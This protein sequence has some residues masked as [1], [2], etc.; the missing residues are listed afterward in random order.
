LKQ[1]NL[2]R[3][4]NGVI[5]IRDRFQ[6]KN[7]LSLW[8]AAVQGKHDM[9]RF[10]S[11]PFWCVPLNDAFQSGG[12]L[13]VYR[14]E[15][16]GL[17]MFTEKRVRG[18]VL[19]MPVDGMW[20]LGTPLL[21]SHPQ[22]LLQS[23][24]KYWVAHRLSEGVR[25]VMISGL[26]PENPLCGSRFWSRVKAWETGASGRM[27]ASLE[28]G[29]DGFMSRRSKNFRS[30][31][32][33]TVKAAEE[34]GIRVEAMPNGPEPEL[35]RQIL[36]R[37]FSL[38]EGSWKGQSGNG[39]DQGGMRR[40]YELM[41]PMLASESRLRGLFLVRDGKDL[42]YLFGGF[43][44]G[45]FRGLQ[46]SYLKEE[47]IGLGNVCQYHMIHRLIDEGCREYDLGQAMKYKSRWAEKHIESR[48]FVFQI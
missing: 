21:S 20:L 3:S 39:I 25:Q 31:L 13:F 4:G 8:K 40:F 18:G 45:Y 38:E 32:R 43:F 11:S 23:L 1:G 33:R 12:P 9:D 36:E 47:S 28:G 10:C 48:T 2:S 35:C 34:D 22:Q 24:L 29:M 44:D 30:R 46:F 37:V 41:V 19:V 14:S 16:G 5:V 7:H 6:I 26:Y 27:V 15:S 17:A 42:A